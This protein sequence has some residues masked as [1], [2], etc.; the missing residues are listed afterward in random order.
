MW[1][2]LLITVKNV[3]YFPFSPLTD[4]KIAVPADE[5]CPKAAQKNP[6]SLVWG[7]PGKI[8]FLEYTASTIKKI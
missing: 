3:D 5:K 7:M 1:I 2:T 8:A 4:S 6:Q